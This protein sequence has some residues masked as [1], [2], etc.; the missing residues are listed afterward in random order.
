MNS[1]YSKLRDSSD[2]SAETKED[3]DA[4]VAKAKEFFQ[5]LEQDFDGFITNN[6]GIPFQPNYSDSFSDWHT[7]KIGEYNVC[8]DNGA[9]VPPLLKCMAKCN[10]LN[11]RR[12]IKTNK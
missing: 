2:D 6:H 9:A 4:G 8:I 1:M 12:G 11:K 10:L 7:R 3:G 5:C